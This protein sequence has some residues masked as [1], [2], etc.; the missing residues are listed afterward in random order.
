MSPNE[1][2]AAV[3]DFAERWKQVGPELERIRSQ[4]LREQTEDEH[5]RAII[6]VLSGPLEWFLQGSR[7]DS[8]LV[9]QQEVFAKLC[10]S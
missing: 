10:K 5:R 4:S 9:K 7:P 6:D 3:R 1:E 8:G 2:A